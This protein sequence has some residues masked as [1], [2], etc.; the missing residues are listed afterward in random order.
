[1]NAASSMGKPVAL[2]H[3]AEARPDFA[4]GRAQTPRDGAACLFWKPPNAH[5]LGTSSC[6]WKNLQALLPNRPYRIAPPKRFR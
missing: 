5:Q 3:L 4:A 6:T 1:M 2:L